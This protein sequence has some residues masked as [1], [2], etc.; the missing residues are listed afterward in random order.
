MKKIILTASL[1]TL[2]FSCNVKNTGS[3]TTYKGS[4]VNG[5]TPKGIYIQILDDFSNL[6]HKGDTLSVINDVNNN[7]VVSFTSEIKAVLLE[8][9]N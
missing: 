1:M 6:Y 3:T 8:E 2:L 4:I 9:P 7:Y 5:D